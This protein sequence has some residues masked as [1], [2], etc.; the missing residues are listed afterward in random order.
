[1]DG[2]VGGGQQVNFSGT[3]STLELANPGTFNAPIAGFAASDFLDLTTFDPTQ[4]TVTFTENAA[5]TQGTLVVKEGA[6][7]ISFTLLGQYA[8][9]GFQTE[10]DS[11]AGTN[12]FYT[13]PAGPDSLLTHPPS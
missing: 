8:A 6:T 7:R 3:G 12:I 4:T 11:G 10:P 9:A 2:S 1:L 13:P 5:N